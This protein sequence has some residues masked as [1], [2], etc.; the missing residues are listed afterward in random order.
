M[1]VTFS[2]SP[3]SRLCGMAEGEREIEPDSDTKE[4]KCSTHQLLQVH[5]WDAVIPGRK[6]PVAVKEGMAHKK[7][8]TTH[9]N[10]LICPNSSQKI[11]FNFC[12]EIV[13]PLQFL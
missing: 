3:D 2:R 1:V 8:V 13:K 9:Y 10:L 5:Q 11:L 12:L 7:Y 6:I 4:V